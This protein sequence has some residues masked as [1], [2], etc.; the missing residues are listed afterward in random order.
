M[1]WQ[2]GQNVLQFPLFVKEGIKGSSVSYS[3][4]SSGPS[5]KKEGRHGLE[6]K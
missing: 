1:D 3:S 5:F 4:N 2:T 6:M